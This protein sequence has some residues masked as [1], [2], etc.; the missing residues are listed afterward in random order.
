MRNPFRRQLTPPFLE[1]LWALTGAASQNWWKDLLSCTFTDLTGRPQPLFLAVRRNYLSF[2]AEG[3]AVCEVRWNAAARQPYARIHHKFVIRDAVGQDHLTLLGRSVTNRAGQEVAAYEDTGT[4]RSWIEQAQTYAALTNPLEAAEKKGVAAVIARNPNVIDVE[5]GLPRNAPEAAGARRIDIVALEAHGDAIR[6][7]FYEAK[8]FPNGDLRRQAGDAEVLA[9]LEHYRAWLHSAGRAE[10]VI[11]AM[12]E[13]CRLHEAF[14]QMRAGGRGRPGL[15]D[16]LVRR[17]G[18]PDAPLVLD[19]GIRLIVMGSAP[20]LESWPK[21]EA[22]L[23]QAGLDG[24]RLVWM[25]D[26]Q[27]TAERQVADP[28]ADLSL[29]SS[30]DG[31]QPAR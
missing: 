1:A 12:R 13:A 24:A 3:Q 7:A 6:L 8:S 31:S 20:R 28:S 26:L 5:M 30:T 14:A 22:K 29:P 25:K 19:H 10:E 11:R 16:D 9:Q 15:L 27:I 23:R 17:A 2:Y 18:Q 4:L 21:H